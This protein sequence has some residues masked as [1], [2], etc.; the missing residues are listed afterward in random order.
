MSTSLSR[1]MTRGKPT[2]D[3]ERENFEKAQV[4]KLV[5]SARV[6]VAESHYNIGK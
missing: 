3:I 1:V 5:L 6:G 4:M 2:V